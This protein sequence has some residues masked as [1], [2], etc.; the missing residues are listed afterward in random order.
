MDIAPSVLFSS[1]LLHYIL[2]MCMGNDTYIMKI[3]QLQEEIS[4][5]TNN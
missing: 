2:R 3:M 4:G 5:V 1:T